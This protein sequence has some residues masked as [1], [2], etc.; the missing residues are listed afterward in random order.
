MTTWLDLTSTTRVASNLEARLDARWFNVKSPAYGAVGNG[1]TSDTTAIGNALTAAALVGGIVWIPPGTYIADVTVPDGVTVWG[2]GPQS[3]WIK[4]TLTSIGSHTVF[5]NLKIGITGNRSA[6]AGNAT[7]ILFANC[8]LFGGSVGGNIYMSDSTF[9]NIR[10]VDCEISGN[11][12]GGNGVSIIDK[13]TVAKH[14][15]DITFT[16]CWFHGNDRFN[17]ECIQRNDVGFPVV[18]GY[19]NVSLYEC[20][21][22]GTGG[23]GNVSYDSGILA[24]SSVRSSGYST[25]RGCKITGGGAYGIELAGPTDMLIQGNEISGTT[26]D[27][28]SMSQYGTATSEKH[29]ARIIG[30]KFVGTTNVVLAGEGVSFTGNDVKTSGSLR[31]AGCHYSAITG[32][33]IET[34]GTTAI[35]I[36]NSPNNAFTGNTVRGGSSQSFLFLYAG[37]SDNLVVG[38]QIENLATEFDVR[39]GTTQ[40]IGK[41]VFLRFGVY[42]VTD[43]AQQVEYVAYSASMT[44]DRAS[45][46]HEI[47]ITNA[48]A[49]TINAPPS[50]KLGH[51]ITFDILNSAGVAHGTVTMDNV[52]LLAGGG[53]T[54]PATAAGKHF[55][56]SFYYDGANWVE[57]SRAVAV[58]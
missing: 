29:I 34:T 14:T 11:T 18:T 28:L 36:E 49:M 7:D 24:D 43:L 12:S 17:F 26:L 3:T 48:T 25:V 52:Y 10:F 4:G 44:I 39:D 41:N 40:Y 56:I 9:T 2:A 57:T 33:T 55:A 1:V 51:M 15:E 58:G 32:N 16:R 5:R 6:F 13:G 30:N 53:H 23:G 31:L 45:I 20:I 8:W 22:D 42:T 37:S 21:L 19:R 46:V 47:E 27:L 54:L 50:R 38:N 35:S